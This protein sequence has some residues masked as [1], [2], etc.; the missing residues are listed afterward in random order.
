M[1]FKNNFYK[2][3]EAFCWFSRIFSKVWQR[4][5]T[6]QKPIFHKSEKTSCRVKN[7][8]SGYFLVPLKFS[9]HVQVP[10]GRKAKPWLEC[11]SIR[12]H[13]TEPS[14]SHLPKQ[15]I[16]KNSC[17]LAPKWI[18]L[19]SK[20]TSCRVKTISLGDF[21]VPLPFSKHVQVRY[22]TRQRDELPVAGWA[23]FKL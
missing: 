3:F 23:T 20:R 6:T 12:Y 8:S 13:T 19:K 10:Q 21:L 15:N 2:K 7:I 11:G 14:F 17:I 4:Y 5:E 9:K 22:Y 18:L 16:S 1:T